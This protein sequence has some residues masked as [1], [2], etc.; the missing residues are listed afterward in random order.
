MA[1]TLTTGRH[2]ATPGTAPPT[3]TYSAWIDALLLIGLAAL[4]GGV[5]ALA[6]RWNAPLPPTGEIGLSP[7]GPPGDTATSISLA[8]AACLLSLVVTR[9]GCTFP[10]P[11]RASARRSTTP[12]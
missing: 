7:R 9:V 3:P 12:H 6:R 8:V 5:A 2:P 10:A 1:P 4:I 11:R